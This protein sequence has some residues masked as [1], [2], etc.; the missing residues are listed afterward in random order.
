MT[1]S[2]AASLQALSLSAGQTST[3]LPQHLPVTVIKSYEVLGVATDCWVQ[4][5]G[6][7]IVLGVSQLEGKVGTYILVQVEETALDN[8]TR[9]NISTLLGKRDDPLWEV[10][11]RRVTEKIA[12]MRASRA[13]VMPPVLLGISLKPKEGKDPKMFTEIVDVLANLYSDAIKKVDK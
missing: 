3:P 8:T 2:A 6:D 7:Q 4:L 9:F 10:Y 11:A 1:D 12:G 5:F 13:E